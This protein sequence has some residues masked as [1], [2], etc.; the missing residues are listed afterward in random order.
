[1]GLEV[2]NHFALCAPKRGG[3]LGTGTEVVGGGGGE[4]S[5]GRS[6]PDDRGGR[7]PPPEQPKC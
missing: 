6:D 2:S 7:G 3:L 5:T 4:G 1:M